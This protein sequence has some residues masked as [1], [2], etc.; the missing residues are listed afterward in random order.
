[1]IDE[2]AIDKALN[3][4][5]VYSRIPKVLEKMRGIPIIGSFTAFP[6]ENLRNKYNV[7]KMGSQEI[8]DGFELGITSK[9]GQ[10]LVKTGAGAQRGC[11]G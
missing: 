6:A 4:M 7:L 10:E 5:P 9:A 1:M 11:P 8:K 3:V 2:I